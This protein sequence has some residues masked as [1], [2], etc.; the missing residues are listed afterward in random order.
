MGALRMHQNALTVVVRTWA[1]G[2]PGAPN[3][4]GAPNPDYIDG[5]TPIVHDGQ[6]PH[7]RQLRLSEVAGSGGAY[8][9]GDVRVGAIT[10][11]NATTNPSGFTPQQLRPLPAPGTAGVEV[12]YQVTGPLGGEYA[13]VEFLGDRPMRYE[14]ILR[15]TDR[16][17]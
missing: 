10:P 16:T 3:A 12:I 6:N 1:S 5:G 4:A 8:R 2:D 11:Y 13:L 7:L 14:L 17:P 9:E 15:R